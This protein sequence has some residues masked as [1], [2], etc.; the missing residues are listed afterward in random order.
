MTTLKRIHING[1]MRHLKSVF[2]SEFASEKSIWGR[3]AI[4]SLCRRIRLFLSLLNKSRICHNI[5]VRMF[6]YIKPKGEWLWNAYQPGQNAAARI[7][8]LAPGVVIAANVLPITG[9]RA[10]RPLAC[11]RLWEKKAM[12]ARLPTWCATARFLYEGVEVSLR[13]PSY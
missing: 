9:N 3:W 6:F 4:S 12:I 5:S 2:L 13:I 8:P 11:S 7:F 10:R 1:V